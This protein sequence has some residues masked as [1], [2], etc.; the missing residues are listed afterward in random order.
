MFNKKSKSKQ[1]E[2]QIDD[3][4]LR[5]DRY[6][7]KSEVEFRRAED[8]LER[9]EHYKVTL[10]DVHEMI[11]EE[12]AKLGRDRHFYKEV[13]R[14]GLG[15]G[16]NG[17]D[18]RELVGEV[19]KELELHVQDSKYLAQHL[20]QLEKIHA[21]LAN[22][23]RGMDSDSIR[24]YQK[25]IAGLEQKGRNNIDALESHIDQ[26]VLVVEG[27]NAD[28]KRAT[29]EQE[30]QRN[31]HA[32]EMQKLIDEY[33]ALISELKRNH[34][35]EKQTIESHMRDKILDQYATEQREKDDKHAA[36]VSTLR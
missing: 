27:L 23:M 34:D 20:Y 4:R 5:A 8:E 32:I 18:A 28:K 30:A 29:E 17:F 19:I 1:L 24:S 31:E 25:K 26:L 12:A 3:E 10:K 36:E 16:Q 35:L 15:T 7:E 33:G 9:A 11:L 14:L 21:D 22:E 2:K 13:Y 6:K